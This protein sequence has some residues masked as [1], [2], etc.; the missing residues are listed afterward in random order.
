VVVLSTSGFT[1]LAANYGAAVAPPF[2]S[3]VVNAADGTS[4]VAPGGLISVYGQQMSPLNMATSQIPLPTALADS[5]LSING[6]PVPLLFVSSGQINAQLPYN[7]SGT[8][9]LTIHTPGGIGNNYYLT[10]QPTAP[11]V[12]MSASAGPQTG[13]AAILRTANNQLVTPTN[14]INPKDTIVIFLTGMGQTTPQ[15][16][17]GLPAPQNPLASATVAPMVTLGGAPLGVSYAGLSP[18]EVGV[19][20]INAT[21]PAGVPQGMSIPL[22]INQGG[23]ATTINVRVVN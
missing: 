22:T 18:N 10:V 13:L 8:S 16:Q 6:T 20:Q 21:V 11:S 19:Y 23:A 12:F 15:V 3:S 17:A 7:V 9:T 14:P 1:V 4:P 5:C 2:I